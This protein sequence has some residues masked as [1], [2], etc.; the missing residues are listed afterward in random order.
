MSEF[1]ITHTYADGTLLDGTTRED[2][3]KGSPVRAALDAQRWKR[4]FGMWGLLGSPGHPARE[5]VIT[6]TAQAL[7]ALGHTVNVTIDNTPRDMA[8]A[9]TERAHQAQ[10]RSE[11]IAAKAERRRAEAAG[12]ERA[13]RE[14]LDHIPPGQPFLT[15]HHSYA[16]DRA[17]RERAWNNQDR[18]AELERDAT[19]LQE[20]ADIAG[21]HMQHRYNPITVANRIQRLRADL[22]KRSLREDYRTDLQ[23]QLAYWTKI[24]A[25]QIERGEAVDYTP[26]MLRRGDWVQLRRNDWYE[27]ER[28]NKKTVSVRTHHIHATDEW[29]TST[30]PL[31][32]ITGH[33]RPA[34]RA[35][36]T[37]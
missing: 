15:D 27:I 29:L 2:G 28:V 36:D 9:E 24:R 10:A 26:D 21:K 16:S 12:R 1:T 23:N 22:N 31:H 33:R 14:V 17:R 13:A 8:E 25:G 34:N 7:R 3:R 35:T 30:V 11:A 32:R 37:Q 5:W 4:S 20:R 6:Q 19:R 18:A